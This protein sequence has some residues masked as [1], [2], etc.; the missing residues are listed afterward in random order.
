MKNYW[1]ILEKIDAANQEK[2]FLDKEAFHSICGKFLTKRCM[3]AAVWGRIS[4]KDIV[5]T[6]TLP[7]RKTWLFRLNQALLGWKK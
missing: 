5:A 7:I 3:N 1:C 2:G 6:T 4:A